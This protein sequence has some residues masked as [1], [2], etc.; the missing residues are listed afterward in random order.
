HR[1]C[2]APRISLRDGRA[3][4]AP[5]PPLFHKSG[6]PFEVDGD[7]DALGLRREA[8][9]RVA[10]PSREDLASVDAIDPG[11]EPDILVERR[12][13]P[14]IDGERAGHAAASGERLREA[15]DLV[16]RGGDEA[17]VEVPRWS[18]VRRAEHRVTLDVRG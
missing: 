16:E 8:V 4:F 14:V 2:C 12:R 6:E 18:F 9:A 7:E 10:R 5:L 13:A 17:A 3:S 15:E 11:A 1:G